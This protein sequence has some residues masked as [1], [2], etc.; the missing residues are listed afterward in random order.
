M[1][2]PQ[3]N[4]AGVLYNHRAEIDVA[5]LMLGTMTGYRSSRV[6]IIWVNSR[7]YLFIKEEEAW[8][9]RDCMFV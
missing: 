5:G 6:I 3:L 8:L 1:L 7:V 9:R 4:L 2:W